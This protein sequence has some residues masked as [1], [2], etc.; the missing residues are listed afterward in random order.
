[1]SSTGPSLKV[2]GVGNGLRHRARLKT[3]SA[4][5]DQAR[6]HSSSSS[7]WPWSHHT[8]GD[9]NDRKTSAGNVRQRKTA[10][11]EA[12]HTSS[13]CSACMARSMMSFMRLAGGRLAQHMR[14]HGQA[15]PQQHR[16]AAALQLGADAARHALAGFVDI[17]MRI[18]AVAG[19]YR[20]VCVSI[21]C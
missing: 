2:S 11:M 7:F 12:L 13:L 8:F 14:Q 21:R 19:N 5:R 6:S 10:E 17:H 3:K 16:V 1:M 9:D 15:A 4:R 20:G 18:G